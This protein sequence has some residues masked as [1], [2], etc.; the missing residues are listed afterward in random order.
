MLGPG[1]RETLLHPRE[2]GG[3]TERFGMGA[4]LTRIKTRRI[5]P[6]R[7]IAA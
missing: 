5:E 3:L 2:E 1:A 4:D 7:G 6:E